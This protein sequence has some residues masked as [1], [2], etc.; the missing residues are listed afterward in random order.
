MPD[1]SPLAKVNTQMSHFQLSCKELDP[2]SAF[3]TKQ[4]VSGAVPFSAPGS[5]RAKC[6]VRESFPSSATLGT[7]NSFHGSSTVAQSDPLFA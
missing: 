2:L 1:G 5:M 7:G 4:N 3:K 6:C